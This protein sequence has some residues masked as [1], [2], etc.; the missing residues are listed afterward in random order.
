MSAALTCQP[1]CPIWILL[2]W[3]AAAAILIFLA[4]RR[5]SGAVGRKYRTAITA[6]R[7]CVVLALAALLLRPSYSLHEVI[8]EGYR[9]AVLADAS[10]SMH[11]RKDTAG[12]QTRWQAAKEQ[13]ALFAQGSRV[14]LDFQRFAAKCAPWAETGT[15]LAG[16]TA[17]GDAIAETLDRAARQGALP[18]GAMLIISDGADSGTGTM[19]PIDAAKKAKAAGIPIS[20]VCIGTPREPLNASVH[21]TDSCTRDFAVSEAVTLTAEVK[22]SFSEPL[23][24]PLS[25]TDLHGKVL[26]SGSAKTDTNGSV[27]ISCPLKPFET[28]GDQPVIV[29]ISPPESDARSD[30]DFDAIALTITPPLRRRLLY[31]GANPG[32]EWRFLRITAAEL[33]AIELSAIIRI[34][35]DNPEALSADDRPNR[36]FFCVGLEGGAIDRFPDAPAAY[37]GFD[38]VIIDCRAAAQFTAEQCSALKAFVELQGGG[39]LFAGEPTADFPEELQRMLP[40]SLFEA[41]GNRNGT[42]LVANPE[43]VFEESRRIDDAPVPPGCPFTVCT[44]PKTAARAILTDRNGAAIALAIGNFGAGRIAWTGLDQTW[45]WRMSSSTDFDGITLHQEFWRALTAWIGENKQPALRP[46][47]PEDPA[48]AGA[49]C[50]LAAEVS[51]ADFRPTSSAKVSAVV[52]HPDGTQTRLTLSPDAGEP[53]RYSADFFPGKPGAYRAD[54]SAL[55]GGG[56]QPLHAAGLVIVKNSSAETLQTAADPVLLADIARITGGKSLGVLNAQTQ[57]P[58]AEN[59]PAITAQH[60]PL[61]HPWFTLLVIAAAAAEWFLR[62]RIGLK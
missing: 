29:R 53:G 33:P 19:P 1:Y 28:D 23:E 38:G 42:R 2:L 47:L 61:E 40:G 20:T 18:L 37:S 44:R 55:T 57:L 16:E 31:I 41:R 30:D 32:W 45:R 17:I 8:P 4:A 7:C 11:E 3:L 50:T 12:G 10:A 26:Y 27:I 34:G 24:L 25:I 35:I 43:L 56:T 60:F 52:T 5:Q 59:L 54:F 48:T 58:T 22:S 62:R 49:A 9:I 21:F 6:L 36:Q 14:Q 39:V 46:L 51:G 13:L 15:P